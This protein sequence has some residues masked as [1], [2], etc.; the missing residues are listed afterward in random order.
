[1]LRSSLLVLVLGLLFVVDQ[2]TC[3]DNG[4]ALRPAM[5]YNT[6]NDYRCTVNEDDVKSAADAV[7]A[8]G[9]DKVG[10][11]YVNL[12]DCWASSRDNN[13]VIQADPQTFPSGIES[14]ADYVHNLG[15]KFGIY[16]DRG[17]ETCAGRPGSLTYES[18]DA[19][20]YASWGVDYLKEDSCYASSDHQTAFDEYGT[21]RD[22][23]NSTG[24]P[25]YFSL[26]GWHTWY[27]PQGQSLGNS[28]RIAGDCVDWE[29]TLNAMNKNSQLASYAGPGGWNDPDMLIG[30]SAGT[31][32]DLSPHQSRTMF[33]MWSVMAAPLLIGSNIHN[34]SS[35]DYETYSNIE[36]ISVDQDDLGL[37][38]IRLAGG[39]LGL[40]IYD[41]SSPDSPLPSQTNVWGRQLVHGSWAVVFLNNQDTEADIT[42]DSDCFSQM[43]FGVDTVYVRDLWTHTNNGTTSTSSYTAKNVP[44]RGG[45]VMVRFDLQFA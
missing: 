27:A 33:S 32:F 18:I 17:N 6:W 26:C 36:V 15:L 45:S 39:N 12:D 1:M 23:L 37:Q 16:T 40:G 3:V 41:A 9:L 8:L 29:T 34:L 25:I 7:I 30:S 13:G 43:N 10:Y 19:Q 38:G 42:C 20:T 2:G 14:L 5:G 24:R 35:W 4:L 31:A 28:W 11:E 44:R 22:A 21:M